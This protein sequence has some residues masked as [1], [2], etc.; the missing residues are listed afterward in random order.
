MKQQEKKKKKLLFVLRYRVPRFS[1]KG[2]NQRDAI[3]WRH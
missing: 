2:Q 3:F 1:G